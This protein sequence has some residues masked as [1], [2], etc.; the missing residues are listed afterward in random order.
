MDEIFI[1]RQSEL[2][3]ILRILENCA[4]GEGGAVLVEGQAGTSKTML[5][6]V[7]RVEAKRHPVLNKADFVQVKCLESIGPQN[8]YAPFIEALEELLSPNRHSKSKNAWNILQKAAP[9]LLQ[10]I[11]VVGKSL[12]SL[13]TTFQNRRKTLLDADSLN[14][15]G[16][17]NRIISQYITTISTIAQQYTPLVLI[18]EDA[19]WLDE[20]SAQ[21]L[22]RLVQRAEERPLVTIVTRRTDY[23]ASNQMRLKVL[24]DLQDTNQLQTILLKNWTL[25]E[26]SSYLTAKLMGLPPE[27]MADWLMYLCNGNPY[28][29]TQYV[30]LLVKNEALVQEG[31]QYV[32][33]GTI[34]QVE[35]QWIVSGAL[36]QLGVPKNIGKLLQQRINR[37]QPEERRL[38]ELGAVQGDYFTSSVV[39]ELAGLEQSAVWLR[40]RNVRDQHGMIQSESGTEHLLRKTEVYMFE[41]H[42]LRQAYYDGLGEWECID[43]H[44]RIAQILEKEI[45]N[46]ESPPR[47]LLLEL[48]YHYDRSHEYLPAAR[49][50]YQAAQSSFQVGAFIDAVE[51]CGQAL[52]NMQQISGDQLENDRL[53]T[54]I[55]G[56]YLFASDVWWSAKPRL[57]NELPLEGLVDQAQRAAERVND[58]HLLSQVLFFRGR[59]NIAMYNLDAGLAAMEEALELAR[60]HQDYAVQ[61]TI[62]PYFGNSLAVRDLRAAM[63]ILY[64]AY[65]LY[66]DKLSHT[67]AQSPTIT[68]HL[69]TLKG[70][71]GVGE[72][73]LGN[74]EEAIV[75]LEQSITGLRSLG[76]LYDVPRM[77]G[78]LG[79][80]YTALGLF[81]HAERVLEDPQAALTEVANPWLAYNQALLG[82]LYLEWDN[83]DAAHAPLT[84]GWLAILASGRISLMPIVRNLYAEMLMHPKYRGR[85]LA[86]AW[87]LLTATINESYESGFINARI[88]ALS[89]RSRIS[90][91]RGQTSDAL[92]QALADSTKAITL[93]E[94]L[95][96]VAII[97]IE[98]VLFTHYQ[99]LESLGRAEAKDYLHRAHKAWQQ[100]AQS[101]KTNE[102]LGCFTDRVLLNRQILAALADRLQD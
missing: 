28:F 97:R 12:S 80:V 44:V 61:F 18:I 31:T 74:Y 76:M 49:Y 15:A 39:A 1:G 21:L 77:C 43:T 37:L 94:D 62:L 8:A 29:V 32:L 55:I 11:P 23:S 75:W 83:L 72:F 82:K 70:F 2:A 86:Q 13:T 81:E 90:L 25:S 99:I 92:L 88:R 63:D 71:I 51:L 41:H 73:D 50:F 40:L 67:D 17:S 64:E 54:E 4:R 101:I 66:D 89:L 19:Q 16:L 60:K 78:Y 24:D 102:Y 20:A 98:E 48:A 26:V 93:L 30:E 96:Q 34:R 45:A 47:K 91:E 56:L 42:L 35:G 38:L 52:K 84:A 27:N 53:R 5:L 57:H 9:D 100:K 22:L 65:R 3:S 36:E 33:K 10:M 6:D 58:P 46:R 69:Y 68:R 87:L 95:G 7:V 59:I 85:D 79:Q 14:Y